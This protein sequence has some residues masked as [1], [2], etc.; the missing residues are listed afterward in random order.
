VATDSRSR[1]RRPNHVPLPPRHGYFSDPRRRLP[2]PP[3]CASAPPCFFRRSIW[4]RGRVTQISPI[5]SSLT[6]L[7]GLALKLLRLTRVEDFPARSSSDSARRSSGALRPLRRKSSTADGAV[8]ENH[9]N[10]AVFV[11][12]QH[13]MPATSKAMVFRGTGRQFDSPRPRRHLLVLAQ[14]RPGA[15]TP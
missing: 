2:L 4:P 8:R 13:G 5:H 7:I 10:V 12:W 9:D 14:S 15:D 3:P 11:L 1:G 6:P